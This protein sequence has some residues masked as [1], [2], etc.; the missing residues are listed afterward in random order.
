MVSFKRARSL[1]V[2]HP[3]MIKQVRGAAAE[4]SKEFLEQP[5]AARVLHAARVLYVTSFVLSTPPR[6]ECAK[7]MAAEASRREAT[8]AL[9]LSSS[10]ILKKVLSHVLDLLPQTQYLFGNADE[11]HAVRMHFRFIHLHHLHTLHNYGLRIRA[12]I[13]LLVA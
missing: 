12:N 6:A 13:L 1:L 7:V 8:F 4:M 10:A 2:V 3:C 9:N 5:E 11:L